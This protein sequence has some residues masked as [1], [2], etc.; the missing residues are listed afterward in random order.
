MATADAAPLPPWR[1]PW[2]TGGVLTLVRNP[3]ILWVFAQYDLRD[4]Y[5]GTWLG[6]LWDYARPITRFFVYF[7]VI[8]ILFQFHKA[9]ENFGVYIFCGI[10]TVQAFASA[11]V[12]GTR[13]LSRNSGLLRRV[14]VPREAIPL[15]AV[16]SSFVKQKSALIILV[17]AAVATGWRPRDLGLMLYAV[18]GTVLLALFVG[19]LTLITSVANMYV[20]DTQYAVS[21]AVTLTRWA[22]PVIY[23]WTLVQDQFGDGWVTTVYLSNPVTVAMY[24]IRA[25]F[26]EPTIPEDRWDPTAFPPMPTL[27][28]LISLGITAVTLGLGLWLMRRTEHRVAS[29]TSWN[30]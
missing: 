21:T 2:R 5:Q 10:V 23:P 17:I 12:L 15:A 9:V 20:K 8:G 28:F 11:L 16:L 29:R 27:P 3:R 7:F 19:G 24:G 22:S 14:N 30:S 18:A 25:A 13:S 26:W 4:K 1:E 6:G